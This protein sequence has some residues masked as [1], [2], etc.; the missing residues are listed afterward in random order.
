MPQSFN[1][2]MDLGLYFLMKIVASV[3][4]GLTEMFFCQKY[5]IEN[6]LLHKE[7]RL[8]SQVKLLTERIK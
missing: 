7:M 6:F 1:D 4:S 5:K 3:L 8:L 2:S